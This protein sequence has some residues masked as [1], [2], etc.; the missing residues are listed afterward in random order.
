MEK[1]ELEEGDVVQIRPDHEKFP[2]MLLVVTEPKSF[3]CQG[4][5]LSPNAFDAVRFRDRAYLR[6]KFEDMEYVGKLYWI[7]KDRE[8]DDE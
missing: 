5:L 1:R 8:E 3:G 4:Y 2:G 7:E 6:P